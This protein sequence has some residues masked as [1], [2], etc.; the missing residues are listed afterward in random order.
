MLSNLIFTTQQ[1]YFENK[2]IQIDIIKIHLKRKIYFELKL[3]TVVSLLLLL[4]IEFVRHEI[5]RLIDEGQ[6]RRKVSNFRWSAKAFKLF[7]CKVFAS[8]WWFFFW[9]E[10]LE[11]PLSGM[12]TWLTVATESCFISSTLSGKFSEILLWLW[13]TYAWFRTV[14]FSRWVDWAVVN[15]ILFFIR[16]PYTSSASCKGFNDIQAK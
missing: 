10:V 13:R 9:I 5:R 7:R 1:F 12:P 15:V 8:H 3:I 16:K 4:L 6:Q 14:L 11:C 2:F